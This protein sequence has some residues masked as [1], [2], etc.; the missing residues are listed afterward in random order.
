VDGVTRLS[1]VDYYAQLYAS[2]NND[3]SSLIAIGAPVVFRTGLGAGFV[4]RGITVVVPGS[5]P[6]VGVWVQMRAWDNAGGTLMTYEAART[7]GSRFGK[8]NIIIVGP[9][10]SEYPNGSPPYLD[11]FLIGLQPFSLVP[12][13]STI[14]LGL[15]GVL[16]F[17]RMNQPL[18]SRRRQEADSRSLEVSTSFPPRYLGGYESRVQCVI[19]RGM[20]AP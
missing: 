12:E 9:L 19:E 10:G 7:T 3:E 18:R 1:G 8:S 2:P 11:P 17:S 5:P 4:P 20:D 16:A 6:G 15:L 14:A 13:P